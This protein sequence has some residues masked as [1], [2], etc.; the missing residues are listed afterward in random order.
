MR[1]E[2]V[3]ITSRNASLAEKKVCHPEEWRCIERKISGLVSRKGQGVVLGTDRDLRGFLFRHVTCDGVKEW[4]EEKGELKRNRGTAG[5]YQGRSA[6]LNNMVMYAVRVWRGRRRK[7]IYKRRK[8][9]V[10]FRS[11]ETCWKWET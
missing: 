2:S 1:S 10:N 5:L 4:V 9:E 3:S 11:S 6:S 8:V 7:Q